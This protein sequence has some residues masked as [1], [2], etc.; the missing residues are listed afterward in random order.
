MLIFQPA[1]MCYKNKITQIVCE[2]IFSHSL[3]FCQEVNFTGK[4][5][6]QNKTQPN[7][8]NDEFSCIFLLSVFRLCDIGRGHVS[9]CC[10]WAADH[11]PPMLGLLHVLL[12]LLLAGGGRVA[13]V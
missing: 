5:R 4:E 7:V 11:H 9:S 12:L 3:H 2:I 8:D 13:H 1:G 6:P 10:L